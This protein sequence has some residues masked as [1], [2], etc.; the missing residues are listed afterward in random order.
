MMAP[1]DDDEARNF[2][3]QYWSELLTVYAVLALLLAAQLAV[4]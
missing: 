1:R 4:A 3:R 2:R